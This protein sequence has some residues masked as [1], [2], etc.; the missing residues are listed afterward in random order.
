[1]RVIDV[2]HESLYRSP[3]SLSDGSAITEVGTARHILVSLAPAHPTCSSC[4]TRQAQSTPPTPTNAQRPSIS[5]CSG[6]GVLPPA[7]GE[8]AMADIVVPCMGGYNIMTDDD[9]DV[10]GGGC[11]AAEGHHHCIETSSGRWVCNSD[12]S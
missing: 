9:D 4:A 3:C 11:A 8:I 5:H 12:F 2:N 6:G 10:C 1:M 7:T